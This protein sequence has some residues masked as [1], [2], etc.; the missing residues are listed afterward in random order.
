M[1]E[2]IV[3]YPKSMVLIWI[4]LSLLNYPLYF[5]NLQL[6]KNSSDFDS[7]PKV[8]SFFKFLLWLGFWSFL[9]TGYSQKYFQNKISIDDYSIFVGACFSPIIGYLLMNI[10]SVGNY[11][12]YKIYAPKITF[13]TKKH[14]YILSSLNF[15]EYATLIFLSFLIT[16]NQF[17]LGGAFGLA[18]GGIVMFLSCLN[19]K[20][21]KKI[22]EE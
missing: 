5:L 17:L 18:W 12:I 14:A 19:E 9:L 22:T 16:K 8:K 21:S 20:T 6:Y 3:Q 1:E 11:F 13:T 7:K 2:L 4:L 15:F 10:L